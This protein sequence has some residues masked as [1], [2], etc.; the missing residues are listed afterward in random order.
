[1]KSWLLAYL[2]RKGSNLETFVLS[3]LVQLL[4]RM[5]KLG[6][7]EDDKYRSIIDDARAF[8]D[9]GA[10][11]L[12]Q[13][14]YLVGL[15]IISGVV[16]EMNNPVP[17]RTLT[18]HRKIAVSFRDL[19]LY[20]AFRLS[21]SALRTLQASGGAI[22]SLREQAMSVA[23]CCLSFDFVGTCVDESAEDLGT[24]QIPSAWRPT[25][26][27]PTTL[28]LFFDYYS[29]TTPPLSSTSLECLVKL[30]STRR[31]L[32]SSEAE[33]VNFLSRLVNGTRDILKIQQ[34][35]GHHENYHEFCRLLG[36]LKT[37]YQLNELVGLECYSEWIGLVSQFTIESLKSWQWASSSVYYLLGL[38][39]VVFLFLCA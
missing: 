14:H 17:G 10:R 21:L 9:K 34:G 2:E 5:T 26:E 32:F 12:S 31:S 6:W 18:Q 11:E 15:R 29:H 35:L 33:R 39:Y 24:I 20:Q 3:S 22:E 16:S 38:W 37:N 19:S 28:A 36:R 1:M 23:L 27:D 7:M 8:L 30:S 25:V 4:S 13:P